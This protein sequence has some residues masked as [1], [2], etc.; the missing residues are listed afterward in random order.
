MEEKKDMSK[1]I[2]TVETAEH[3][4][5][6]FKLT[7]KQAAELARYIKRND[8]SPEMVLAVDLEDMEMIVQAK[9]AGEEDFLSYSGEEDIFDIETQD[10][11]EEEI[12]DVEVD[13]TE[14]EE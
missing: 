5:I 12:V 14:E 3:K 7:R 13:E 10:I 1:T 9:N 11:E 4:A 8:G 2:T 6:V